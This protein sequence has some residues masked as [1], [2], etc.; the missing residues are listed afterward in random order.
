MQALH[1]L[2]LFHS[3][4]IQQVSEVCRSYQ[5]L[6]KAVMV[7]MGAEVLETG[8]KELGTFRPGRQEEK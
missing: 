8:L 3:H 2:Q 6:F 1:P 7:A 4:L 5:N